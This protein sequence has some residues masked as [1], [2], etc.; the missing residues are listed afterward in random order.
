MTTPATA[1]LPGL[2]ADL[3]AL[4]RNLH[5][6]WDPSARALFRSIDEDAWS[7]AGGNPVR[8]L[9]SLPPDRL[10]RLA[11]DAAF[12]ARVAEAQASLERSLAGPSWYDGVEGAPSSIGYF[13]P[14]FG[15]SEI[16]P[17]YSGGLG[18]LAGD[19][20]KAAGDLGLPLVGVGLL[21]RLGYFE[22]SLSADG[23]QHERYLELDPSEL[24][25]ELLRDAD[26][27]PLRVTVPFPGATLHAQVW[28]AQVG[29]VPL[30]LLDSHVE[31]NRPDERSVTDR[32][33]G[34]DVE[35][36][37]RQE[38]A[39]GIGGLRALDAYGVRPEV[40]HMNEGHAGFLGLERIRRLIQEDGLD[41]DEAI[42]SVRR[43]T[44]FTT[45][46]PVPAGIDRFPRYLIDRYF[47]PGGLDVGLTVDQVMALGAE[48]GGDG[49]LFN[50]AMMGLRLAGHANG[51]SR[52]H[53]EVSRSMFHGLWPD[54]EP[55]AVPIGHIT[56]GVHEETWT[57]PEALELYGAPLRGDDAEAA[58]AA[59][60]DGALW[61]VRSDLRGRLVGEVRSRL[62]ASFTAAGVEDVDWTERAFDPDVL[63]IGFARRVPQYKRLTLI[64]HDTDR[65]RRLLLDDERPIQ[66]VVAG[67]AHPADEGGKDLIQRFVEFTL[68][69]AVRHRI[70]FLPEYDMGMARSLVSG[71][72]VWLNNPLRPLEACGTS[73]MKAALN[74]CLN[75]SIRDGWWDELFDGENGWAIPTDEQHGDR[76]D[77]RDATEAA[78]ILDLLEHEVRPLFYDRADGVPL[79]WTAKIKRSIGTIGPAVL[80]SRMV[81][82]YT[83]QLY[84]PA[85]AKG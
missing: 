55:S 70:A 9:R 48:P 20:L 2:P 44:I 23:R 59:V 72:D 75:L 26:G 13:S 25:L 17:Q 24:P 22:Q 39:L 64:L 69:P 83:T 14:E 60:D 31:E 47:G 71:T 8:L 43:G 15:V 10:E 16:L 62:R 28:K 66:L 68:D 38:I 57:A 54:R 27:A 82:D 84:V 37:I 29:R 5:S 35:T 1:P 41:A 34:G 78:A 53:G 42:A 79:G 76:P 81:R 6:T 56:N 19:H 4:A 40:V 32:L 45:H 11:D 52:L 7:A 61:R 80:A 58:V 51:V 74:G 12:R 85:A 46:T 21:Y 73:G 36:R 77:L 18:V 33:Y 67:K 30:L 50:M 65:L 63:T 49:S 3:D